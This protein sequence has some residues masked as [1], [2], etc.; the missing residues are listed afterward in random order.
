[1]TIETPLAAWPALPLPAIC[2]V[3]E[4]ARMKRERETWDNEGGQ[5]CAAAP[6]T[7][8]PRRRKILRISLGGNSPDLATG[9]ARP[10]LS[11]S[12]S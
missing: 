8:S 3:E 10:R 5:L 4:E 1:M 6:E 9:G 11:R 7:L 2:A 12:W